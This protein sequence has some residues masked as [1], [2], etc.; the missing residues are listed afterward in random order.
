VST[1]HAARHVLGSMSF[2]EYLCIT[3]AL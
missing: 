1:K 3:Q 2:G